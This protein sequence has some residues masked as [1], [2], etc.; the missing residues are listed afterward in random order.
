MIEENTEAAKIIKEAKSAEAQYAAKHPTMHIKVYSPYKAYFDNDGESISAVNATGPF[1]VLPQ[2]HRFM[3]LLSPCELVIRA[4]NR[5]EKIRIS[6]GL[7]HVKSDQV[8]VF[9]DI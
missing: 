1:D 4:K 2:H 8:T 3:T 7:M 6:G 5:E 9:L